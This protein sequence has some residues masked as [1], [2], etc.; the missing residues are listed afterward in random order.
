MTDQQREIIMGK[1][2]ALCEQ[3]RADAAQNL[4][5]QV[6]HGCEGDT[7]AGSKLERIRLA[8]AA[9]SD[10]DTYLRILRYTLG[11]QTLRGRGAYWV[12]SIGL[13]IFG[14][15]HLISCAILGMSTTFNRSV[16]SGIHG[17]EAAS[18]YVRPLIADILGAFFLI[19]VCVLLIS[20]MI[21]SSRKAGQWVAI[22]RG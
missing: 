8:K 6:R 17:R 21:L 22:A 9:E 15:Y 13:G 11:M 10:V 5:L 18:L 20:I 12:A 14:V 2:N 16:E 19:V 1:A 7:E 4:F 3:G